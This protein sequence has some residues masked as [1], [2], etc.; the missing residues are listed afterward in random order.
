MQGS[1]SGNNYDIGAFT[2]GF[3]TDFQTYTFGNGTTSKFSNFAYPVQD[4][5]RIVDGL[6]L[7]QNLEV[8]PTTDYKKLLQNRDIAKIIQPVTPFSKRR[9]QSTL[10]GYPEPIVYHSQGYVAGF[11]LPDSDVAVLV[12]TAF[13]G[14][15][16]TRSTEDQEEHQSVIEEFLLD[17]KKQN[18]TKLIVD[19][20]INSGGHVFSGIDAFKQFFPR[21][22]PYGG[23]R[24]RST[25][26]VQYMGNIFSQAGIYNKTVY[27]IY[28]TASASDTNNMKFP[29]WADMGGPFTFHGDN[30][31]A[32]TRPNMSDPIMTGGFSVSGYQKKVTIASAA[33]TADNIV[34]LMDGGCGSTCAVFSEMMKTQGGV[35][36]GKLLLFA[37]I[38]I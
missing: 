18:R 26:L 12:M 22:E 6:S 1:G 32:V 36:T 35:R 31:L 21:V 4:F 20:S 13:S 27:P 2:F 19:L 14:A 28:S 38:S 37:Q 29:T 24:M 34:M 33:F 17:C 11:L 8:K 30:F 15:N 23:S 5:A 3:D 16:E 10:P 25:P 7:F 9:T